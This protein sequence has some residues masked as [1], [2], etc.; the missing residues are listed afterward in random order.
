MRIPMRMSITH[1]TLSGRTSLRRVT[2]SPTVGLQS[3]LQS[4]GGVIDSWQHHCCHLH[5]HHLHHHRGYFQEGP[6]AE[7]NLHSRVEA[8]INHG[9]KVRSS[10]QFI[11]GDQS[12]LF[13]WQSRNWWSLL[14]GRSVSAH[15]NRSLPN[16]AASMSKVEPT[17]HHCHDQDQKFHCHESRLRWYNCYRHCHDWDDMI[18]IGQAPKIYPIHLLMTSN[19]RLPND[20]D[21]W[22]Y[23]TICFSCLFPTAISS[24]VFAHIW[25]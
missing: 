15:M 10:S 5:L 14:S 8:H 17:I 6:E 3:L 13:F 11:S 1:L 21:R 7:H 2:T 18:F 16:M 9:T 22:P 20:A 19:Y 24:I 25:Y 12:T 23:S 4:T